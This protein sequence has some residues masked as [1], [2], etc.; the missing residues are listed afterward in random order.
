MSTG[1][2]S[3]ISR[4]KARHLEIC[5]DSGRYSIEGGGSRL[6][7]VA[8]LHRALPEL[9]ELAVD[10]SIDFLGHRMS[11][12][13][14]I[15]CMTGG[16]EGGGMVNRALAAAAQEARIA[17]GT[18]SIRIL[19]SDE[20]LIDQF[21]LKSL[22]PDVPVIAN[23]G[24]V[25]LRELGRDRVIE[26]L[27][28]LEVQALALHLNAAQEL[29]QDE[30]DRDFRGLL[31]AI[32]GLCESSPIPIIV[33]ETG[34]GILPSEVEALLDKGVAF[35]DLAAAGGTNWVLVE[36]YRLA[37]QESIAA[38]D[39]EDWGLPIALLLLALSRRRA[40]EGAKVPRRSS[41]I[42]SGGLRSGLD[43][44]KSLALG[45][46]LGAI[47]LPFARAAHAGGKE[48]VLGLVR[49]LERSLRAAMTLTGCADLAALRST[50]LMVGTA[51][52]A[53]AEELL[54]AER[55]GG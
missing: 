24:A 29:F 32:A 18:G 9:N 41:L 4:R 35:V 7:E 45:A 50:A 37:G 33:K 49:G 23:L 30:G 11:L 6:E 25:Q 8:L 13:L 28:R 10:T 16:S 12:P 53:D 3:G 55:S 1:F 39:F 15:S 20:E 54:R 14:L 19:F 42:A 47:A 44:A 34:F 21:R 43:L 22:A 36:S 48:A 31:D 40:G 5:V 46:E 26:V 51:L 2:D 17:V 38:R 52:S 27:R